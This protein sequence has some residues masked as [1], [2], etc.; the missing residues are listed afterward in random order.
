MK[1]NALFFLALSCVCLKMTAQ[2]NEGVIY[3]DFEPDS[4][5]YYNENRIMRID[6]NLDNDPDFY[7]YHYSSLGYQ[8]IELAG[9]DTTRMWTWILSND[10]GSPYETPLSDITYHSAPYPLLWHGDWIDDNTFYYDTIMHGAVKFLIDGR[11]YYSWFLAQTTSRSE[12]MSVK[13]VAFC[14]IPDYPLRWGQTSLNE[15]VVENGQVAFAT[16]RPNPTAG[17]FTITG[18]GLKQIEIYDA[19]GQEIASVKAKGDQTIIDLTGQPAGVYL[20][21]VT[22]TEG[23][24]CVK[25][26]VRQ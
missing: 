18:E 15:E 20:V 24:R 17:L 25:K 10:F 8:C 22:D 12:Y 19:L 9:G 23:R 13:E 16:V 5:L 3:R 11:C 26:L 14:T 6:I 4:I 21:S 7:L 1:K 2:G